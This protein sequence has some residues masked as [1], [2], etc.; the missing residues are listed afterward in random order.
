MALLDKPFDAVD[1]TDLTAL[2]RDQIPESL[3]LDYKEALPAWDEREGRLKLLRSVAA[4]AN[5]AGGI[6]LYGIRE[7]RDRRAKTNLPDALVGVTTAEAAEAEQ[8]IGQLLRSGLDPPLSGFVIRAVPIDATG[9]CVLALGSPSSLGRPHAVVGVPTPYY[10]RIGTSRHPLTGG[11]L[12]RMFLERQAWIRDADAFR[13]ARVAARTLWTDGHP[14]AA[15]EGGAALLLHLL[16]LG[17]IDE[18]LNLRPS[19]DRLRQQFFYPSCRGHWTFDGP[20]FTV[21]YT[22]LITRYA[23][24]FRFGGVE[25]FSHVGYDP[26]GPGQR[27]SVDM[28]LLSL[29]SVEWTLK[30]VSAMSGDLSVDPPYAVYLSLLGVQGH[31]IRTGESPVFGP[32]L[33][34]RP[35]V[36]PDLLTPIVV[37]DDATSDVQ[38]VAAALRSRLDAFWQAAGVPG[39]RYYGED[40]LWTGRS[41]RGWEE[42][43]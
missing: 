38:I 29:C 26:P 2:V 24:W 20:L 15:L 18:W 8:R 11:E 14:L 42:V 16:P 6:V 7:R 22:S 3:R 27:P 35:I 31:E 10:Q 32:R 5:A 12:R 28:V 41:V 13:D 34:T 21:Q 33:S 30:A 40:G 9:M 1:A 25:L 39:C 43:G 19:H 4:M 17:R 36:E 37:L 23:Q